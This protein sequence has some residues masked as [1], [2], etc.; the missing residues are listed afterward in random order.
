[1]LSAPQPDAEVIALLD[2]V[3]NRDA[4]ALQL[5]YERCSSRLYGLALRVVRNAEHAEDVLQEAFLTI[6]R[7]APTYRASLSPPL[8]WMGIIV[9]SRALDLLRRQRSAGAGQTQEFDDVMADTLPSAEPGPQQMAE[10]SQ[11]AWV[12]HQCLQQLAPPQREALSLAY[13]R[14][15]S[16]SELAERLAQPLGT[17]KTWIRRSLD[18]LRTCMENAG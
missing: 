15:M 9:R 17:I 11:Q 3:A 13:M 12:L 14:E 18:K 4:A 2:R 5:L 7:S 8:A 1:M 16:H 6:W 10:T